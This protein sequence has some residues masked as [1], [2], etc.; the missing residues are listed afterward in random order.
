MVITGVYFCGIVRY[1]RSK[2]HR[3]YPAGKTGRL[4]VQ[5]LAPLWPR[6]APARVHQKLV[7]EDPASDAPV[8]RVGLP[9]RHHWYRLLQLLCPQN[10][11][12]RLSGVGIE[13][14]GPE[15]PKLVVGLLNVE[16]LHAL[17]ARHARELAA[18]MPR[19]RF[20]APHQG[21]IAMA[22]VTEALM[23]DSKDQEHAPEVVVR[24]LVLVL[25]LRLSGLRLIA[26]LHDV[27]PASGFLYRI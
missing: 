6:R 15:D 18:V 3:I 14:P 11:V 12:N 1:N 19:R 25:L 24:V 13:V 9:V 27:V 26:V 17:F 10:R 7:L 20:E 16:I 8:C 21:K 4:S 5:A 23:G 22:G 2:C